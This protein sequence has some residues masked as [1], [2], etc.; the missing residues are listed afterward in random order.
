MCVKIDAFSIHYSFDYP[1]VLSIWYLSLFWPL[2]GQSFSEAFLH[3]DPIPIPSPMCDSNLSCESFIHLLIFCNYF[4]LARVVFQKTCEGKSLHT[5]HNPS[6]GLNGEPWTR[7]AAEIPPLAPWMHVSCENR[8]CFIH[9]ITTTVRQSMNCEFHWISFYKKRFSSWDHAVHFPSH[10]S[11]K[12]QSIIDNNKDL[13][14]LH[15]TS[16]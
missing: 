10:D 8:F 1:L 15:F 13:M 3:V 5:T 2:L 14:M 16:L 4:I 7:E 6:S 9:I 11:I 12:G